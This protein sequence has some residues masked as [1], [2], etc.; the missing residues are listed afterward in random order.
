MIQTILFILLITAGVGL[1]LTLI[2]APKHNAIGRIGLSYLLGIGFFTLVMFVTN[3]LGLR[4]NLVHTI[5]IFVALSLPLIL[6]S[7]KRFKEYCRGVKNAGKN[8]DLDKLEKITLAGIF[9][10]VV[11]SFINTLYWPVYIWDAL[12]MYDFRAHVFIQTG[13]IVQSLQDI[14]GGYYLGYPLFTSLSHTIVYLAGGYNPQFIYSLFYLSL[15]LVF[16]G[17]L[18]EFVSRKF[19]LLFTLLLLVTPQLFN[20]S[21]VAYTNLPY[22][23]CFALSAIYFYIWDK[24][25]VD[26]YLIISALLLGFSTWVRASEPFWLGVLGLVIIMSVIRKK[27]LD[28]ITFSIFFFPIQ[29]L[30]KY[31][32]SSLATWQ[33]STVNEIA[34]YTSFLSHI[35]DFGRWVQVINFLYKNVIN[36]WGVVLILFIVAFVYS[37]FTNKIRE[38]YMLYTINFV[39]LFMLLIGNFIFSFT[40]SGWTEIPDSASRMAMFIYPLFIYNI[41]LIANKIF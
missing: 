41:A 6:L 28:M 33:I 34:N 21:L 13:F 32:L 24:K 3:I 25:R 7:H 37:L 22:T 16:Y 29:Q 8:F 2:I 20:Q 35:F 15:G 38:V 36:I 9:F 23:A 31:T 10:V 12:T 11:S 1:P 18:R 30:W 39:L 40:F 17:Q 26:G 14:G 27:Y 4:L 5:L 19:S